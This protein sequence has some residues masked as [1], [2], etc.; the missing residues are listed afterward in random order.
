MT[1]RRLTRILFAGPLEPH[2][3][4][5]CRLR[6]LRGL[7][8]D[9]VSLDTSGFLP[10][11]PRLVRAFVQRAFAHPSVHRL[12]RRLSAAVREGRPDLVW[13][14]KG[15]WVYPWTLAAL[16]RAGCALVHYN[17]DDVFA[18]HSHLWLH[19]S[20]LRAYDL[21]LTT[22]RHN[23]VELP[24]RYG[25]ATVRAGMGYDAELH[26]PRR[27]PRRERPPVVFVG[28]WEP[29]TE[30]CLAALAAAGIEV[31]LWGSG[32]HRARDRRFRDAVTVVGEDYVRTLA[33]APVALGLLSRWNRNE[34][35][36]RSFEI[37]AVGSVLLAERTP[38]PGDL[39]GDGVGAVLF[40]TPEELVEK[41]RWLLTRPEEREAIAAAGQARVEQLGCS[42]AHH[43]RREWPIVERRL[44]RPDAAAE[45][46][47]DAPFWP[48]YRAGAPPP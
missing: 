5:L 21:Y 4:T 9:V 13:I 32:W 27:V 46:G 8:L 29:H 3:T 40:S 37:P 41:A 22:N 18:P 42:W 1:S 6:A 33:E 28:H 15:Q 12:N 35:T 19:R 38:E 10:P 23:V 39:Y 26:S 47:E 36:V 45:P 17:T 24:E 44:G 20:G 48:G 11:G 2:S 7:G 43:L 14:D 31:G 34:S 30:A 25:V 16:R